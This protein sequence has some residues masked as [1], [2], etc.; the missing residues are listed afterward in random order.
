M[1]QQSLPKSGG[2]SANLAMT[3]FKAIKVQQV[4]ARIR[5]YVETMH[6]TGHKMKQIR[7]KRDDF[8]SILRELNKGLPEH[9][10]DYDQL[11][12]DGVPVVS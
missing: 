9:V 6:R 4:I 2:Q 1:N 8:A 10:A 7:I 12:W 5:Q 11:H 3:S